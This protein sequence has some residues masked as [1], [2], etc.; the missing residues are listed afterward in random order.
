MSR[1]LTQQHA[2]LASLS[3]QA[4]NPLTVEVRTD[5]YS[6][7]RLSCGPALL[8]LTRGVPDQGPDPRP[9]KREQGVTQHGTG[10]QLSHGLGT[11]PVV[12]STSRMPSAAY[13]YRSR[14]V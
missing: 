2:R 9:S 3:P 8:R 5:D 1:H 10:E 12:L 6:F 11:V 13:G 14:P 7:D 4:N